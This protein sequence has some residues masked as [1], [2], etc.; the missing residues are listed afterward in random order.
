MRRITEV[1]ALA[2]RYELVVIGAGPA[3]QAAATTAAEAGAQVLLVDENA[4][5]G[6]QI[7]RGIT[8]TPVKNR[9]I[10]GDDYWRGLPLAQAFLACRADYAPL[11]KLFT[12]LPPGDEPGRPSEFELGVSI[13]GQARP[14]MA[15]E[16]I[17]A[18]GALERPFPIPGWTLPGVLTAGAAQIALKAHGLLPDGRVVLAGSGPLLLLVAAQLRAA[19]AEIAAVLDTTPAANRGAALGHALDFL[20]SPY[21]MK[22]VKLL[23]KAQ[24]GPK[25]ITGVTAL[26]AEGEGK[27]GSVAYTVGGVEQRTACD[28]LLLHQGVV[29]NTVISNAIGCEHA[30]DDAQ[31]CWLP[32]RD[33]WLV[34]SI[35]GIAIVGDGGGIA[36][37]ECATESGRLA[38]LGAAHRLGRID[39]A[40][41][42]RRAAPVRAALASLS[43]GRGFLDALYRPAENFR[44][45]AEADTVVCRCEEVTAGQLRGAVAQGATGPNQLKVFLRCGMGPCQGRLCNL[46]VTELVAAERGLTPAEI[47]TYRVRPPFKPVTVGEIASLPQTNAAV[48]AVVRY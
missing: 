45:P 35:P 32:K 24:G 17:I 16:V 6:G 26:R 2:D 27:L 40:E 10:L 33:G 8:T 36:G 42:D 12:L 14:I 19:G 11:A 25:R 28:L 31:L 41:R 4:A 20:R 15:K 39:T 7:Y 23:A 21:L 37:A 38:A 18:T 9:A 47:G 44:I 13:A 43:R 46:T 5:P 1:T 22:G 29:P 3:G 34:S 30:W 48:K